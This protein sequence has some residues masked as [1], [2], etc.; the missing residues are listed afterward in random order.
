MNGPIMVEPVVYDG[1]RY[2]ALHW[3]KERDLG[4]NGGFIVAIDMDTGEELWVTRIYEIVY[5]DKSPQKYDRFITEISLIEKGDALSVA[6]ETGA[7]HRLDL[8]TRAVTEL[9][10]A[11]PRNPGPHPEKPKPVEKKGFF[12]KLFG[13]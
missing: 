9:A 11:E 4:Q 2:E 6:D 3:G 5:G 13:Q 7:V 12:Q 1:V 8:A 10:G